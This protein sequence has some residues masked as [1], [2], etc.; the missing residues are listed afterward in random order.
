KHDRD[1]SKISHDI[2]V[3]LTESIRRLFDYL[4]N[5]L[6]NELDKYLMAFINSRNDGEHDIHT[7]TSIRSSTVLEEHDSTILQQF[8]PR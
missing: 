1:L 5:C 3:R 4:I 6:Q 2:Q 7:T 8:D